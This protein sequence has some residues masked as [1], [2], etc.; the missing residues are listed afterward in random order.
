MTAEERSERIAEADDSS[1]QS[2]GAQPG[3]QAYFQCR[4]T[5]DQQR[6]ANNAALAV[7]I[8]M[9]PR[10]P[11]L[12]FADANAILKLNVFHHLQSESFAQSEYRK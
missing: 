1:C 3:S 12:C 5:K 9:S 10:P 4:V 7:A 8:F 6:R 11:A 2:Y